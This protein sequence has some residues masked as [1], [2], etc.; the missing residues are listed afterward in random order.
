[1]RRPLLALVPAIFAVGLPAAAL[2]ASPSPSYAYGADADAAALEQTVTIVQLAGG[3]A[4]DARYPHARAV[5]GSPSQARARASALDPGALVE[6]IP[7]QVRNCATAIPGCHGGIPNFPDYPFIAESSWPSQKSAGGSVAEQDA[8]SATIGAGTYAT[9][10]TATGA[11]ADAHGTGVAVG[12][13]ALSVGQADATAMATWDPTARATTTTARTDISSVSIAGVVDI[14][15]VTAGATARA[16]A[17]RPGDATGSLTLGAVTVAG[18]PASI[19]AA[20]V[21]LA[22]QAVPL[23]PATSAAQ[24][25]LDNLR[26]AGITIRL[27]PPATV[28][29][30]GQVTYTGS[31]LEVAMP[32]PQGAPQFTFDLGR[33]SLSALAIHEAQLPAVPVLPASE[34]VTTIPGTAGVP[35]TSGP[36]PAGQPSGP[37]ASG[38]RGPALARLAL[39]PRPVLFA[40]F[41]IFEA[42]MLG[43][44]AALVWP[45]Q[46]VAPTPTLTSL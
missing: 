2:A 10:V 17:G 20:G 15:S 33:L 6:S 14:A 42:A 23:G 46:S 36:M 25:A 18:V 40:L 38:L 45:R 16:A 32:L 30:Q 8:G 35:G 12:T 44:V 7:P 41:A 4:V 37:A 39:V 24:A 43:S 9:S 22:G 19:D 28:A 11:H 29:R 21:H 34:V 3:P 13:P 27:L 5:L 26:Q 31:A 1:M